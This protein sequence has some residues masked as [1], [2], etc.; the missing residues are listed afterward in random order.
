[1]LRGREAEQAAIDTIL[2]RARDGHGAG[3]VLRGEP[4]IRL[5]LPVLDRLGRLP[6]PQAGALGV[7]VAQNEGPA[8]DRFLVALATLSLLSELAD[9]RPL[10][11]LVDDAH[12]ADRASLDSFGFV[13]RRL[14]AEPIAVVLAVRADQGAAVDVAGLA[15]LPLAGL[16]PQAARALLREHGGDRLSAAEQEEV[17]R[18][19]GGNPLAI[20]EFA[21]VAHPMPP[22]EPLPLADGLQ[23]A[24]LDRAQRRDTAAQRLLLLIAAEGSGRLD[25]LRRAAGILGLDTASFEAGDCDDLVVT[26]GLGVAFRHPLIR[27]AVY[28]GCGAAQRRAAHRALAA[29]MLGEPT[30]LDRRAWHLAH[31]AEGPDEQVAVELERS[32]QRAMRHAGAAAAAAA[33]GRAAELS[34]S[35]ARR[36]QR[37]VAAAT[38]WLHA[39]D[40]ARAST[41]LD[42]AESI[43]QPDGALRWDTA[44]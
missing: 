8:P 26:D 27:S 32:A 17:L 41:L 13:A 9:E 19:S 44:C 20:R 2:R 31:A 1:M 24:F 29:A 23:R 14:D 36:A 40:T 25:V 5:L 42:L 28:H 21:A 10:L 16:N 7:V 35:D 6:E 37:S 22:G 39:G 33:L 30:R 15:D 4:G 12:W 18:A 43:G 38:S 34:T 3:L 11:C